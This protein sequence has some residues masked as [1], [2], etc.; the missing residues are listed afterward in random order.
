MIDEN[1][2]YSLKEKKRLLAQFY[3]G[4]PEIFMQYF[5]SRLSTLNLI[6]V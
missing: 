4:H 6:E 3:K 5:G 1:A 2:K